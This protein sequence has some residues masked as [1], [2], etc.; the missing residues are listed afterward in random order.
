M[1]RRWRVSG[2]EEDK[3]FYSSL[4]SYKVNVNN[5]LIHNLSV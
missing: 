1:E 3:L 4:T 2:A 5:L